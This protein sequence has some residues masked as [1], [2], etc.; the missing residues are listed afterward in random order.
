M[1]VNASRPRP[2]LTVLAD[3]ADI[4]YG[5]SK[6]RETGKIPVYGSGGQ[7][8]Y[9]VASL[10]SADAIIVGRKGS[11][12]SIRWPQN[13]SWP[14]DTTFFVEPNPGL[15]ITAYLY[16]WL[17]S[18]PL[19]GTHAQ[20]TL[21]SLQKSDLELMP[22]PLPPL[23]EQRRIARILSAIQR[24]Q[25]AIET[26]MRATQRVDRA[27]L[28]QLVEECGGSSAWIKL[29]EVFKLSSGQTRP[30]ALFVSQ[31]QNAPY[32][33]YGGNGI[34]G[35]TNKFLVPDP[36]VIIGRVGQYCGAVYVASQASWISDNALYTKELLVSVDL[37]YLGAALKTLNLNSYQAKS[38]QPL[39][40][41]A[42]IGAL[43]IPLPSR[44]QQERVVQILRK[45]ARCCETTRSEAARMS[46]LFDTVISHL[47]EAAG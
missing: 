8:A 16:Y 23:D 35:F 42:I 28:E 19:S 25:S 33:V 34:M 31:S 29:D 38:A 20:T 15:V 2:K 22:L 43:R 45:S 39:V 7:Y 12:G 6:P 21:P 18:H 26:K 5:K 37:E 46:A 24:S 10:A 44:S 14:S 13:A 1:S 40:T 41:Q 3:V 32:P 27:L 30:N 36:T 47:M 11:A 17:A 9:T 4:R